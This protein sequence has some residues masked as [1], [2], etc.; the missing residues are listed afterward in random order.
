M[1]GWEARERHSTIAFDL[2]SYTLRPSYCSTWYRNWTWDQQSKDAVQNCQWNFK[3]LPL[4]PRSRDSYS[5]FIWASIDFIWNSWSLIELTRGS[6][7]QRIGEVCY[8]QRWFMSH[9]RVPIKEPLRQEKIFFSNAS[10]TWCI[11]FVRYAMIDFMDIFK[12]CSAAA[13]SETSCCTCIKGLT[14]LPINWSFSSSSSFQVVD[15]ML[16]RRLD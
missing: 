13:A 1:Q 4:L 12:S 2:V 8:S 14:S 11:R 15:A 6:L 3:A 10:S 9:I 16:Y 5:S 7:K